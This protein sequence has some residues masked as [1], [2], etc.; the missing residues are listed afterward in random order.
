MRLG[1]HLPVAGKGAS[2]GIILQLAVEAERTGLDSAWSWERLMRPT[3]P[4]A[5]GG[6]GGPVMDAPRRLALCMTRSMVKLSGSSADPGRIWA[7]EMAAAA[8]CSELQLPTIFTC[9]S[10]RQSAPHRRSCAVAPTPAR[11]IRNLYWRSRAAARTQ[12]TIGEVAVWRAANGIHPSDQPEQHSCRQLPPTG[13][14]TS[15]EVSPASAKQRPSHPEA[16][17]AETSGDWTTAPAPATRTPPEVATPRGPIA[18][19]RESRQ[20]PTNGPRR[21][22]R[23]P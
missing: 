15:T 1:V 11:T 14:N 22:S 8:A 6:A 9:R 12:P 3:V 7:R 2:P 17:S 19:P 5:L 23:P 18:A 21:C 16:P 4:T 20:C 10:H 13:N